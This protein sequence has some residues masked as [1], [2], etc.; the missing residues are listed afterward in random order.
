MDCG[1]NNIRFS[2]V[3]TPDFYDYHKDIMNEVRELLNTAR[4]QFSSD[5]FFVYDSYN[6]S[7]MAR[8]R[9]YHKCYFMQIVSV[10]GADLNVYNC[11]NK[12]YDETGKIGSIKDQKFSDLW[13]L[14]E[15][16]KYFEEFDGMTCKHQ[17]ANDKKNIF[18]HEIINSYGDN[19]V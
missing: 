16:K 17:C 19:Y 10:I 4:Q 11:H 2:P 15:T 5:T 14:E 3:W 8:P 13:F 18:I 9:C 1:I 6:I 7:S 12:A